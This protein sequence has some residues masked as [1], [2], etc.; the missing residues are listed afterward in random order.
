MNQQVRSNTPLYPPSRG[1][2]YDDSPLEGGQGGVAL[3]YEGSNK[4]E[5]YRRDQEHP[6]NP[7][8]GGN[9][10]SARS[11]LMCAQLKNAIAF[12]LILLATNLANAQSMRSSSWNDPTAQWAKIKFSH[13]KHVGELGAE[14]GAC[15][16]AAQTSEKANDF[17]F[18]KHAECAACHEQ[19]ESE[20]AEDC[21]YCHVDADN[22]EAFAMPS[23]E[24]IVFSHK[25][26]IEAQKVECAT[27]HNGIEKSEKPSLA[28]LPDMASC[29]SCH[30]DLKATSACESCHP[31][32]ETM[33]P[34]SHRA[35][36]W[37]EQHKRLV[38]SEHGSNDCAVCHS[39]NFCQTCHAE[40]TSQF[41]RGAA[42]RTVPEGRPA[43]SGK[44][45]AVQQNVHA[46]NY[47]F[48]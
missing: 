4:A 31:R 42:P 37:A 22:P 23:R 2:Y 15:H 48:V 46:L 35:P 5:N 7:P 11:R 26:H 41:T 25:Q 6:P 19:V 12:I 28:F 27:C 21:S 32:I 34:L 39:E 10:S 8:Q 3:R 13:Q 30:N 9:G 47:V 29:N 20:N 17:L 33:R 24:D 14:C 38:R 45:P 43:P 16:A 44:N 18:P 40:A 1:E 36:D